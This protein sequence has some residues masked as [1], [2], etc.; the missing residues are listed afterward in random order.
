MHQ[1]DVVAVAE[2]RHHLL[3]LGEP[4]QPVIDEHAG[5]LV[6]DR[7]VDQHR[8]DRR[9][10]AARQPADHPALADLLAD[11]L[12]R[13]VLEGAH[14]PVAGAAG[15][16]AHEIAQQRGAMRRVHHFEM[17]LGGVE[18]ARI[19]ADDGD[20]RVGRGAEHAEAGRQHGDTVAMA[21]P[22]RVFLALSA[23]RRRTAGSR[24][25]PPP[26][27]GRIRGDGR[28]RLCR[29]A[30]PPWPARRSRCR[31]PARRPHRSPAAP[32]AHPCRAPRP[33]RRRGSPPWGA[34][35]GR[36]LR[37]SDRARSR[38]RPSP[39]APGAR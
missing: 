1:R 25:R 18:L 9:V 6:A 31:A 11:F 4:H 17:E 16:L 10:D 15:D 20:R 34:S 5:E 14:G 28:L 38:N 24:R 13:L 32:A 30:A 35:R 8:G 12:D 22:H 3:R 23:R 27:R 2:Q 7:L 37:P 36:R 33:A 39:R 19:V 21:H 26:R 29:R